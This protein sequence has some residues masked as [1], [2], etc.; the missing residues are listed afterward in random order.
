MKLPRV[1][2]VQKLSQVQPVS[3]LPE[4]PD[5]TRFGASIKSTKIQSWV[6]AV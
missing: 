1:S 3:K 2:S 5:C 4:I 6:L